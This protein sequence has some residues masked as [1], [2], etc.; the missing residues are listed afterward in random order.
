MK[1]DA[2]RLAPTQELL[3][4]AGLTHEH[5]ELVEPAVGTAHHG[6]ELGDGDHLAHLCSGR[7]RILFQKIPHTGDKASL[8]RCG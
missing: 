5:L 2:A 7:R 8:D 6:V 4:G 3:H 1:S